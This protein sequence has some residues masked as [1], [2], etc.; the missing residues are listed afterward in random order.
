MLLKVCFACRV[1]GGGWCKIYDTIRR[2]IAAT[3]W[4]VQ[5]RDRLSLVY[6]WIQRGTS[7]TVQVAR[8]RV[9]QY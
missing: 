7:S 1:W 4:E 9:A 8:V 3:W 2:M 5:S 6:M